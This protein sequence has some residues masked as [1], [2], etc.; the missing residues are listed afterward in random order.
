MLVSFSAKNLRIE[1]IPLTVKYF[2]DRKSNI[3]GNLLKYGFSSLLIIL[4]TFRD[5]FP[6]R[7]FLCLSSIFLFPSI[8]LFVLFINHYFVTGLFS[9]YLFAGLT[10]AFLFLIS[11]IFLIVGIIAD[12]LSRIRMNQE[13]IIYITRK[14]LFK[15]K[16][17]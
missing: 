9:G 7:F 6:M 4:K 14:L 5:Y 15:V 12:M 1:E 2:E 10:S 3:S 8:I 11:L 17:E 13:E 16:G